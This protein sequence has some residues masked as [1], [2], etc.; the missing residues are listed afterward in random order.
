MKDIEKELCE[1]PIVD[2]EKLRHLKNEMKSEEIMLYLAEIFRVMGDSTRLKIIYALSKEEL[3][4]HDIALLLGLSVSAVSHQLRI[5]RNVRVVKYR[6]E[7]KKV[8]YSLDDKHIENLFA[9]G[10]RH[11]EE[12]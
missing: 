5:L 3:C 9:E 2:E 10:L 1:V 12:E 6:K 11:V 4:V 8:Y 7:G